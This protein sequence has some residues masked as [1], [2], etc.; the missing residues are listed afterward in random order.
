MA[1]KTATTP[2]M[3][4]NFIS[5]IQLYIGTVY[6]AHAG[7]PRFDPPLII[8]EVGGVD[9]FVPRLPQLA[10]GTVTGYDRFFNHV[11]SAARRA[12]N[13]VS[14]SNIARSYVS[15]ARS[16]SVDPSRAN[17]ATKVA[18]CCLSA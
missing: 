18:C 3:L 9:F 14:A 15:L 2:M 16:C 10:V 6:T 4:A 11:P 12:F 1:K 5:A 8:P 17:F 13:S 7:S